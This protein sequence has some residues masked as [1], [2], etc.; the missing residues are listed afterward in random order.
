MKD[1]LNPYPTY[2]FTDLSWL[3][4]VPAE[5]NVKRC[6]VLF[7]EKKFLNKD[8]LF[9]K[10]FQFKFGEIV[11]KKHTGTEDELKET[12]QK[13]TIVE[14]DDIVVNGLNLNYDFLTQRV[15]KVRESGIITSAYI[16]ISPQ[17]Q[18]I[19]PKKMTVVS[20]MPCTSKK[21]EISSYF[22]YSFHKR[23]LEYCR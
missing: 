15:G 19:D 11:D 10:A 17:K 8:Y 20:I 9:K 4:Q 12:Y 1:N 22:K 2:K 3:N 5:W 18:K 13:Y 16:S 23:K 6:A 21:Y 7:N 14:K